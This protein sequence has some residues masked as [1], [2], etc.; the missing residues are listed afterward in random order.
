M[1]KQI[2]VHPL[3]A[4][5]EEA[6]QQLGFIGAHSFALVFH[7]FDMEFFSIAVLVY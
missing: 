5:V 2:F 4:L 3:L 6:F 1:L 7:I